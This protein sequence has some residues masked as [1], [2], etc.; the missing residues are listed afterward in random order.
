MLQNAQILASKFT[1]GYQSEIRLRGL[2][3]KEI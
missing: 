3:N 2:S 1:T